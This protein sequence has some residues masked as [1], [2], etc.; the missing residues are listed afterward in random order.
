VG[1]HSP[2]ERDLIARFKKGDREA[3]DAL[4]RLHMDAVAGVARRFLGDAHEALDVAQEVFVAAFQVLPRW[5]GE[6]RLFT[7]LY[8]TTLNLCLKRLR[9]R[10][11]LSVPGDPEPAAPA[12]D[13]AGR[14]EIAGAIDDAL[15][16]LSDRQREVFVLCHGQ[17]VPLSEI[18][19][20]L[21]LSLG[22][23]KSHLH[24]ALSTLRDR[25]KVRNLL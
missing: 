2:D 5:E 8:R 15:A 22:A 7:W 13:P 17:G 11:R 6:A 21:G 18:A 25:L 20:R 10:V 3:F 24:R 19:R 12:E 14:A 4:V 16:A 1:G 9:H 23:V